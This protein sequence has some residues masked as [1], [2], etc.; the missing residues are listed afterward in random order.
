MKSGEKKCSDV[1]KCLWEDHEDVENRND[2]TFQES[3]LVLYREH[4][5]S[6][7]IELHGALKMKNL[8]D[9]YHR[10]NNLLHLGRRKNQ[11]CFRYDFHGDYANGKMTW[12]N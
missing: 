3:R 7:Q 6:G 9:Q 12:V 5:L 11:F 8:K 1:V 4:L 10:R 2:L